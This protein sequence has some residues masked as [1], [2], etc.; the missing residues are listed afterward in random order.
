MDAPNQ[1][2]RVAENETA[3]SLSIILVALF[4]LAGSLPI[5][6]LCGIGLWQ[7]IWVTHEIRSSPILVV[8]LGFPFAFAC[9]GVVTAIGLFGLRGWA[10]QATLY[11]AT[12][13]VFGCAVFLF[14]YQPP[15]FD[16]VR[17]IATILLVI[18]IV[19]SIWWWVL[20]TSKSVRSQFER[21][22]HT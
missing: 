16:I 7:A 1:P 9:V 18:L 13:Q 20:F 8:V 12:L 10:R 3:P 14:R 21:K 6:F 5:L 4:Q 15:A 19:V 22:R 2:P 11:L 17:P